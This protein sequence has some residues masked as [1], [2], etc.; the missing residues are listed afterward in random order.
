MKDSNKNPF[1]SGT[2]EWQLWENMKHNESLSLSFAKDADRYT[3]NS[4]EARL[5]HQKYAETLRKLNTYDD[6]VAFIESLTDA[7]GSYPF[8]DGTQVVI[9]ARSVLTKVYG[10]NNHAF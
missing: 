2:P 1:N 5:K 9:D 4:Y 10:R 7:E 3:Q 6:L 8:L